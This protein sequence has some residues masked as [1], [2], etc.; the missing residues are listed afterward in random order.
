M[1]ITIHES[2][3][4]LPNFLTTKDLWRIKEQNINCAEVMSHLWPL[5][6]FLTRITQ[7]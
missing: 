3:F 1:G 5:L 7:L 6:G 4:V 2:I